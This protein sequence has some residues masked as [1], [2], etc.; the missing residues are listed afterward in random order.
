[1]F[2][3]FFLFWVSNKG[4]CVTVFFKGI[5]EG[6]SKMCVFYWFLQV[7]F[8]SVFTSGFIRIFTCFLKFLKRFGLRFLWKFFKGFK[9]GSFHDG[10]FTLFFSN[11]CVS[12]GFSSKTI[13]NGF[14]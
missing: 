6:F 3:F 10:F 14:V 1:M 4:F 8:R 2:F 12:T 11:K 9:S 13:V 5:C 7:D